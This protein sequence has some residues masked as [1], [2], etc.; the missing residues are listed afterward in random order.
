TNALHRWHHSASPAEGN[1]NYGSVLIV[2][3]LLFN[4]FHLPTGVR[5]PARIGIDDAGYPKKGYLKQLL[6][7]V[8][9]R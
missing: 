9:R 1:R 7:S 3:D 4:T 5:E 8:H 2:W 6:W